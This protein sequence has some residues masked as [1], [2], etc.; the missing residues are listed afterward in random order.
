V[1]VAVSCRNLLHW[2]PLKLFSGGQREYPTARFEF[3][4]SGVARDSAL[5]TVSTVTMPRSV[6]NYLPVDTVQ[7]SSRLETSE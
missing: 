7:Q 6:C 3:S 2:A 4:F 1:H 5:Y